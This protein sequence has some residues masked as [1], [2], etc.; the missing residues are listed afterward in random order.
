MK[1]LSRI[2]LF[3]KIVSLYLGY[4]IVILKK[5]DKNRQCKRQLDLEIR[6]FEDID[7]LFQT[8]EGTTSN[9]SEFEGAFRS[10]LLAGF[11]LMKQIRKA[12][13]KSLRSEQ[14]PLL[15]FFETFSPIEYVD[16]MMNL[17]NMNLLNQSPY[18][19]LPMRQLAVELGDQLECKH[20]LLFKQKSVNY[21]KDLEN[22]FRTYE[23][24]LSQNSS[25]Y[26]KWQNAC[27]VNNT[28]LAIS[29]FCFPYSLKV[30]LGLQ[31]LDLMIKSLKVDMNSGESVKNVPVLYRINR[32]P[33]EFTETQIKVHPSSGAWISDQRNQSLRM[34][35]SQLPMTCRPVPWTAPNRGGL[36]IYQIS[37]VR[38][39][40]DF[41]KDNKCDDRVLEA[42]NI[43]SS[44]PWNINEHIL[45]IALH[46][47][48]H[49]GPA[50]LKI[51][52][53]N[54]HLPPLP[55]IRKD[56]SLNEKRRVLRSR[57]EI[58][59]IRAESYSLWCNEFYRLSVA[60]HFLHHYQP[61]FFAHN[62]DF[63]GRVYATP[64]HFNHLG[65]DVSRALIKFAEPKPL[66]KNGLRWLKIHLVNL[67]ELK[68]HCSL[69]ER[70]VFAD[71]MIGEILDSAKH[72][73][74]GRGWWQRSENPWQTLACCMEI[75]RAIESRNPESFMSH[76]PVHQDG[77]CNVL[78]HYAAMGRDLEGA[79]AVNLLPS[80]HP[81]DVYSRVA[82]FLEKHRK[83]DA[84]QAGIDIARRLN[85]FVSRKLV[86]QTVM[87]AVYGVTL[88]G[89]HRQISRR[90][91]ES[92]F[93]SEYLS[94]ATD[95]VA[96]KTFVVLG[97]M[98]SSAKLIQDWL[99][100]CA[101]VTSQIGGR[102]TEWITP[103]GFTNKKSSGNIIESDP[104]KQASAMPPNFVHSLDSTHMMMTAI[105]CHRAGIT[106]VS[107]HDSYWTH[108]ADVKV[109]NEICRKQFVK[110]HSQNILDDL[111]HQFLRTI[112]NSNRIERND[113]STN[114]VF[115]VVDNLIRNYP[116][117][118]VGSNAFDL[119]AVL[120]SRYFFS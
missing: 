19:S 12:E 99:S 116:K 51:P 57:E 44:V 48:Q 47:F 13:E 77:S 95:Y 81:Q 80:D 25:F 27:L 94:D 88:Y 67:T 87:T 110:L 35:C 39:Q 63:R 70:E 56:L 11:L 17:L 4:L 32:I 112:Y 117:Q 107:V 7:P 21:I 119:N 60:K 52:S 120:N 55:P 84:D 109:L 42:L 59:K 69:D 61:F 45:D 113:A 18:Y 33:G 118:A 8:S 73:L 86:K 97:E 72:P 22:V 15:P 106:F 29:E 98:F 78:Q 85:G 20:M 91:L 46:V 40:F 64:P 41:N 30:K 14:L 10:Q 36:L 6:G 111:S 74:D 34:H 75:S 79:A 24:S 83:V 16:L 115:Y 100:L 89:A 82:E 68:K 114:R 37:M 53:K 43:V 96:D 103:L 93:P 101:R 90:L 58:R 23:S 1:V 105:E 50:N 66:G 104:R 62:M 65:C 92:G 26:Q 76:F 54:D 9:G 31:L 108:A 3:K 2:S 28:N 49:G 71:E 38:S 102:L 5:A